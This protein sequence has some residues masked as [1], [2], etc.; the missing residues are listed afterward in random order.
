MNGYTVGNIY[1]KQ[2]FSIIKKQEIIP[3]PAT[4]KKVKMIIPREV[5]ETG[6]DKYH[7]M[8][9]LGNKKNG[10]KCTSLQKRNR[11]TY[12]EKTLRVTKKEMWRRGGGNQLVQ[13][14]IYTSKQVLLLFSRSVVSS[15]VRPHGLC[16]PQ[17]PLPMGVS[18]QEYWRG[19][20]FPPPGDLPDPGIE[21]V[22]PALKL[23][24]C[25]ED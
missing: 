2:Y 13:V 5:K 14:N 1:P 25:T 11:L 17:A 24:H 9:L 20:P 19:V 10:C 6:T 18:R 22:S 16:S 3:S 15:S 8:S 4:E 7:M 12:L 23:S 21:P